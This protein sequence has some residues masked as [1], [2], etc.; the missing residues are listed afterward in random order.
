MIVV[1][2]YR[3]GTS[4]LVQC[5]KNSGFN[6]GH[7]DENG[8]LYY[9]KL[10]NGT[11]MYGTDNGS[12][13]VADVLKKQI[14]NDKI[15]VLKDP[16]FVY[17]WRAYER[18]LPQVLDSKFIVMTRN[19]DDT[20]KSSFEHSNKSGNPK[21][22]QQATDICTKYIDLVKELREGVE[23]SISVNLEDLIEGK[24]DNI[25]SFVGK[26]LDYSAVR[27]EMVRSYD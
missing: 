20:I 23:D 26:D 17:T 16:N 5:L 1:V 2:G 27:K 13:V 18:Y 22:L 3:S 15:E 11:F 25:D 10:A 6:C 9:F 7:I 12:G 8:E 14:E 24:T 19:L 21:T 4:V